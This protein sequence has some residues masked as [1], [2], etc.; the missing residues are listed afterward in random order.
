MK[1]KAG[2]AQEY[3]ADEAGGAVKAVGTPGDDG[4]DL[5][6]EAQSSRPPGGRELH[7][8][9]MARPPWKPIVRFALPVLAIAGALCALVNY[10]KSRIERDAVWTGFSFSR[11]V[12]LVYRCAPESGI[13]RA[14]FFLWPWKK[15]ELQKIDSGA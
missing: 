9:S 3:E 1:G 5:A 13:R 6:V 8:R 11:G 12:A 4:A 14:F 10:G 15:V 7:S 2:A